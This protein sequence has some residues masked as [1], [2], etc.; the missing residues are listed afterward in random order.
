MSMKRSILILLA[1]GF[2]SPVF[3]DATVVNAPRN[4]TAVYAKKAAPPPPAPTCLPIPWGPWCE[5]GFNCC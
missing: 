3:A 4:G 2:A 1:L 5:L